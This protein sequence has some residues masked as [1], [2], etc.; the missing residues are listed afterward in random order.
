M[1]QGFLLDVTVFDQLQKVL[2]KQQV[3]DS[4]RK[5]VNFL[6]GRLDSF[7]KF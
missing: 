4:F 1:N 5:W 7:G 2:L 3:E 6:R